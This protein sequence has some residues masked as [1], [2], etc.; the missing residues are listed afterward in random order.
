VVVV[1]FGTATTFDV[2]DANG[3][4]LGGVI[5]TGI[6]VSADALFQRAARLPRV[7]V[8]RPDTVI[9]RNTTG[10]VQSGLFYGYAELVDGL[11]RRIA[12][13]LGEL[14]QVV[15]TGG[16]SATIGSACERVDR[17]DPLLT[18]EG[19]RLISQRYPT[20]I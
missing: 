9:G 20:T 14:P 12:D 15:A 16:W 8:A 4:Y 11:L 5:A 3:A 18:L 6:G 7:H 10:S 17:I 19:L 13:E 1:D 2:V